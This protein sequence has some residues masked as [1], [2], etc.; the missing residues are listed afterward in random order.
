VTILTTAVV[1]LCLGSIA[2]QVKVLFENKSWTKKEMLA[3]PEDQG[4]DFGI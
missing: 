2:Q 1:D 3:L 4:V